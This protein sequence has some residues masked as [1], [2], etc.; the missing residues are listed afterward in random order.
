MET[1][2]KIRIHRAIAAGV[3]AF[4]GSQFDI[5]TGLIFGVFWLIGEVI[6]F[7]VFESETNDDN[8]IQ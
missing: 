1:F 8:I 5:F 7:T 3:G 2:G 4:A 6:S